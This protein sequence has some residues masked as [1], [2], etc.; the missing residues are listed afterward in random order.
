MNIN[1]LHIKEQGEEQKNRCKGVYISDDEINRIVENIKNNNS[2]LVGK[3][4]LKES[5][6]DIVESNKQSRDGSYSD[7][8]YINDP[9]I[10]EAMK[11]VI[12]AGQASTSFIQRYFKVGYA[13]AGRIIDQLEE[14]GIISGYQGSQPREVL[15]NKTQWDI[16]K[17]NRNRLADTEQKRRK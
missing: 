2:Y 6:N 10:D 16:I 3:Y 14:K 12:E 5:P 8:D 1:F 9:L 7:S 17:D 15:I 13:R 11:I 4:V